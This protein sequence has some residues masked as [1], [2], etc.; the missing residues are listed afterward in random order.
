MSFYKKENA[1]LEAK[2]KKLDEQVVG[3]NGEWDQAHTGKTLD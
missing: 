2:V 3:L 1:T